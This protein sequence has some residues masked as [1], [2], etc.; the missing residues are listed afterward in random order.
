MFQPTS[1]FRAGIKNQSNHSVIGA[2]ASSSRGNGGDNYL[3]FLQKQ[4]SVSIGRTERD[5]KG[6]RS[7]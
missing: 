1:K 4:E 7:L 5:G 6:R 3:S 2:P